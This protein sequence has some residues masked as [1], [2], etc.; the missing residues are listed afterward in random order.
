MVRVAGGLVTATAH[1]LSE[2]HRRDTQLARPSFANAYSVLKRAPERKMLQAMAGPVAKGHARQIN[3]MVSDH[4]TV[5]FDAEAARI[6]TEVLSGKVDASGQSPVPPRSE[7]NTLPS[8]L[9]P[10][11]RGPGVHGA[12]LLVHGEW[13]ARLV[14]GQRLL[15]PIDSGRHAG[16][17]DGEAYCSGAR[18]LPAAM[19][20]SWA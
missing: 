12:A 3:I 6:L 15:V 2:V 1:F 8:A 10:A 14:E 16:L 4:A 17:E 19:G 9:A 18:S 7:T 13:Y 11:L 5:V 20:R